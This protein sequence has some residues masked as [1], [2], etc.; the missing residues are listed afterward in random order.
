MYGF[1]LSYRKPGL[2]V[3]EWWTAERKERTYKAALANASRDKGHNK[4]LEHIQ[5]WFSITA[6]LEWW[7]QFDTYRIG[8]SKQSMST[9]HTL[10][11]QQIMPE[12]LDIVRDEFQFEVDYQIYLDYIDM[13]NSQDSRLKSKALPQG[14]LQE[15]VVNLNYKVI[16]HMC[17]QRYNHRIADW[18]K[19]LE[20]F[21]DQI[22]YPE[23]ID[24]PGKD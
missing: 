14:Y 17:L 21:L 6:T 4:F 1:G 16:R 22:N 23:F 2:S 13:L 18:K 11:A 5:V 24:F 12:H 10:D 9:M 19:L 20:A 8:V 15:R 7:K 3:A